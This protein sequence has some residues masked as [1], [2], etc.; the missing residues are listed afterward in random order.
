MPRSRHEATRVETTV[1]GL[2][3][4]RNQIKSSIGL[5]P[6]MGALHEGHLTL[7]RQ[8]R[9][10]N[11]L[12]A[13]SIFVN[14]TQFDEQHDFAAYPRDLESDLRLLR[15][16]QVELVFV[17]PVEEMYPAGFATSIDV[18]GLSEPLEGE[19]RPGHFR[20]VATVVA[21]L[22]T[23]FQPTRAYFGRKD[24]Q[25]L[26]IIQRMV[27]DLGMPISIVGSPTVREVD[28]LA[29]SSRNRLLTPVERAAAA[30]IP[31]A[32]IQARTLFQAGER[33]AGWI[34]QVVSDELAKEP[35]IE[36]EY[37]TIRNGETLAEQAVLDPTSVLLIAVRIGNVRLIDNLIFSE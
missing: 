21:R 34:C 16:Q 15:E 25:Q 22:L 4:W 5:V 24:Y 1:D 13:V 14:P 11:D 8:A 6:T 35:L 17:P 12:V 32:I 27:R 37:V 9:R 28:G 29:F 10:E 36:I 20:G 31:E 30:R 3:R 33:A 7:V 23:L 19:F 18:A 2:R 26:I